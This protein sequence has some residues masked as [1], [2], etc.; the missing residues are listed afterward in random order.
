MIS[1]V[2]G[3]DGPC[4]ENGQW[5][6]NEISRVAAKAFTMSILAIFRCQW[7]QVGATNST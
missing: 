4:K 2:T 7:H 5:R 6:T 1:G 3:A